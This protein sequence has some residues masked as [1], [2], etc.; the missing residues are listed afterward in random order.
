MNVA[1][2]PTDAAVASRGR[3]GFAVVGLLLAAVGLARLQTHQI[4]A[5]YSAVAAAAIV[6]L[7]H[8]D[9]GAL[10]RLPGIGPVLA[11]RIVDARAA[12]G[13]FADF[14]ELCARVDGIGPRVATALEGLVTFAR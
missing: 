11:R 8:D 9:V 3:T 6:D 5:S 10:E 14:A 1:G 13:P 7:N 4:T 12:G 2:D